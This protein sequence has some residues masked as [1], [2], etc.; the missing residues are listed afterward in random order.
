MDSITFLRSHNINPSIENGG[1]KST[2]CQDYILEGKLKRIIR[3]GMEDDNTI[4]KL[5]GKRGFGKTKKAVIDNIYNVVENK[6]HALD[7]N[8][9]NYFLKRL[10]KRSS[11]NNDILQSCIKKI[12]KKYC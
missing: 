7:I 1:K 8:E 10:S 5:I 4:N 9:I 11:K 6:I 3:M 2:S 12:N